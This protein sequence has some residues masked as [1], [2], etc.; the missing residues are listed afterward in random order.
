VSYPPQRGY[1]PNH[2]QQPPTGYYG[3]PQPGGYG[4]GH[5]YPPPPGGP[6]PTPAYVAAALFLVGAV[7]TF[8]FAG[9]S[10]TGNDAN[11]HVVA[12]VFGLALSGDL[13]GNIDFA[14]T[15][16]MFVGGFTTLFALLLFARLEP[17]R[18]I[19]GVIG[20][21]V[22]AYYLYALIW[23][24]SEDAAKYVGLTA[25]CLVVWLGATILTL[26]PATGRA[27]RRRRPAYPGY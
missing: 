24:L 3:V 13:T 22:S 6:N 21:I 8:T 16:S 14:I 19:L 1:P 17:I 23:L 12:A 7:L 27:M 11:A 10:W 26:L 20:G 18:W 2:G 25:L 15:A 9:M 4:S 5:G